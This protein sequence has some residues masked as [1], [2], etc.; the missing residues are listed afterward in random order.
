MGKGYDER[1]SKTGS[2]IFIMSDVLVNRVAN[3]GLIQINLD[4]FLPTEDVVEFD[5]AGNLYNGLVLKEKEF[6]EFLKN[7]DFSNFKNK[8]VAVYCSVDAIIPSWAYMLL[9][10]T[11]LEYASE[12]HYG[13]KNAVTE[14]VLLRDFKNSSLKNYTGQKV[15][16]KGCGQFELSPSVY[17]QI[18]ALLKPLVKSLMFGE[19]C[20]SVPVFKKNS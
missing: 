7:N 4:D 11:L 20:S 15:L 3:S 19:A 1:G 17:V 12:V 16:L 18:T 10:S 14:N 8:I 2:W 5:L 6:R 13:R 9:S